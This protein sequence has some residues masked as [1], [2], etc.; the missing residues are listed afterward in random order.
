[1]TGVMSASDPS[2][3]PGLSLTARL[4]LV[5]TAAALFVAGVVGVLGGQQEAARRAHELA[6]LRRD[7]AVALAERC[8]P[9][10]VQRDRETLRALV[11]IGRDLV[12]GRVLVLDP[13]GR[14]QADSAHLLVGRVIDGMVGAGLGVVERLRPS[15]PDAGDDAVLLAETAAPVRHA[16]ETIGELR[17]Q[18][19]PRAAAPAFDATWFGL[20]LLACLSIVVV[21]AGLTQHCAQRVRSATAAL[22]RLSAGECSG[23]RPG[24]ADGEFRDFGLALAELERG[25][26]D[27]LQQ[28][29]MGYREMAL[30]LVAQ[31]ER[32]GLVARGRGERC[33]A[34]A[35]RF[36]AHLQMVPGDRQDLELAARLVDLGKAWLRQAAV[37][38]AVSGEPGLQEAQVHAARGAE[39]L[40][41]MPPLRRCARL[42][43]HLAERYDGSGVPHGLRGNRIPLGSRMLA[44]VVAYDGLRHGATSRQQTTRSSLQH[45]MQHAGSVFDPWLVEQFAVVLGQGAAGWDR[46]VWIVPPGQGQPEDDGGAEVDPLEVVPDEPDDRQP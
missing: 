25:V 18:C 10:L 30:Q 44:I 8:A 23:V 39:Q 11:G 9:P 21:A 20:C 24:P 15:D 41:R 7:F 27:G 6:A 46:E 37:R 31:L 13:L 17:L 16:G 45:L 42:L 43:R 35:G 40:D 36:A 3:G 5:A 29:A 38:G 19:E 14:V 4:W 34:L 22:L 1:M 33:A 2:A 12:H 28:V 32:Q 26:Q